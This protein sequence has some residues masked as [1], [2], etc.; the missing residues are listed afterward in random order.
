MFYIDKIELVIF[1]L[2]VIYVISIIYSDD[3]LMGNSA[4][5]ALIANELDQYRLSDGVLVSVLLLSL[6]ALTIEF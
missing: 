4:I 3:R 5:F 2:I 1:A 6:V